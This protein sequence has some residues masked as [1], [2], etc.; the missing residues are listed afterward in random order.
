MYV[1]AMHARRLS[2]II[3]RYASLIC[4]YV[5]T[6]ILKDEDHMGDCAELGKANGLGR[7]LLWCAGYGAM[8]LVALWEKD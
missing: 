8:T 2:L 3:T 6:L 7:F 4:R 1:K 5:G